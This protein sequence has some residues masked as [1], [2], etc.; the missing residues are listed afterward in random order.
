MQ[1]LWQECELTEEAKQVDNLVDILIQSL[2]YICRDYVVDCHYIDYT[3]LFSLV[4]IVLLV[5]IGLLI[6]QGAVTFYAQYL[7]KCKPNQIRRQIR[8]HPKSSYS[9]QRRFG[10][11]I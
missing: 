6:G 1:Y 10:A 11:R 9:N 5:G 4:N 8:R 7:G 3:E 2:E